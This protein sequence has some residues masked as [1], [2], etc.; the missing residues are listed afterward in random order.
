MAASNDNDSIPE[1]AT[2]DDTIKE[3]TVHDEEFPVR[4]DDDTIKEFSVHDEEFPVRDDDDSVKEF[5]V[6]D[7]G[8]TDLTALEA[9]IRQNTKINVQVEQHLSLLRREQ[10]I[11]MLNAAN[12][13]LERMSKT[14]QIGQQIKKEINEE[15]AKEIPIVKRIFS[16]L[17]STAT[18]FLKEKIEPVENLAKQAKGDY[19]FASQLLE[20]VKAE[21]ATVESRDFWNGSVC[22]VYNPDTGQA[23]WDEEWHGGVYGVWNPISRKV[24]WMTK[25]HHG[26]AGVWNPDLRIIEWK[27]EW[28]GGVHGVWNPISRR[29][30]WK[31]EWHHG[32]CGVWNPRT[33]QVEWKTH[34][35]G[36]V[37]G[38]FNHQTGMV[39]WIE[40]WHHGVCLLVRDPHAASAEQLYIT[41]ASTIS[42][43][44]ED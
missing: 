44:Y 42:D 12:L 8:P 38:Y 21:S 16:P 22:G 20:R 15:Y 10:K 28:N 36:G 32:V 23:E 40:K 26:V 41:C 19:K 3:F 34:W 43:W 4:D 5:T 9:E 2:R 37:A 24:E 7:A 31:T 17:S 25:W 39:E 29:V 11:T 27:E 14:H 33:Q 35:N 30:E 18:K 6:R 1:V 13:N